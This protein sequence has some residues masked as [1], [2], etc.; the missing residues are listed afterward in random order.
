MIIPTV[1]PA[2]LP[3]VPASWEAAAYPS[4]KPLSSWVADLHKRLAFIDEW[5]AGG[6]PAVVW[7][8]GLFFPQAFLTAAL[9]NYARAHALPVDALS[10]AC[11]FLSPAEAASITARPADGVFVRGLWLEGARFDDELGCL[12]ES[13]P[14][15]LYTELPVLHLLPI[16]NRVPP[17]AGVYR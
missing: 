3:Q 12:M 13:G 17:R 6:P 14:K 4:L 1:L 15:T 16:P 11:R 5:A 7:L 2:D 8:P 10:F 9:Q